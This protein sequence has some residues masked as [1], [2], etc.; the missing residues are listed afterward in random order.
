MCIYLGKTGSLIHSVNPL[1]S[2]SSTIS[3]LMDI[4]PG[5][6]CVRLKDKAVTEVVWQL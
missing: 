4:K 1:L 6:G 2:M 3:L 5:E